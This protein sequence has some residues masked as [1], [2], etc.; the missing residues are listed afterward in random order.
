MPVQDLWGFTLTASEF[1][2]DEGLDVEATTTMTVFTLP[3]LITQAAISIAAM[4]ADEDTGLLDAQAFVDSAN[5][6]GVGEI[7]FP[8]GEVTTVRWLFENITF[9]ARVHADVPFFSCTAT[10]MVAQLG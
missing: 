2:G 5:I 9:A 4:D 1:G 6:P 7:H 8:T 3:Q 10:I